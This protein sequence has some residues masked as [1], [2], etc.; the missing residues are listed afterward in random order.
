MAQIRERKTEREEMSETTEQEITEKDIERVLPK[1]KSMID[2]EHETKRTAIAK[3]DLVRWR[4]KDYLHSGLGLPDSFWDQGRKIVESKKSVSTEDH[5]RDKE[6]LYYDVIVP[7]VTQ[8]AALIQ[9]L[10]RIEESLDKST[11]KL[12]NTE[13]TRL[14]VHMEK[15]ERKIKALNN[16]LTLIGNQIV[17]S[18]L[19]HIMC[20]APHQNVLKQA[21]DHLIKE[22]E[23][24]EEDIE[25]P[26]DKIDENQ[27]DELQSALEDE[28]EGQSE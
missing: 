12:I 18:K 9:F 10:Q 22:Y 27:L 17:A 15:K 26:D 20:K 21:M 7:L 25:I 23:G 1:E 2:K 16:R 24:V 4:I 28:G 14:W 6:K 8:Y 3:I 19:W 5:K 11:F 13:I